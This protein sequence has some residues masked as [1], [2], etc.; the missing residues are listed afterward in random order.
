MPQSSSSVSLNR[1]QC[2]ISWIWRSVSG[3]RT[4]SSHSIA[5]STCSAGKSVLNRGRLT[6]PV[7]SR[8]TISGSR[9]SRP[10]ITGSPSRTGSSHS[11]WRRANQCSLDSRRCTSSR[12]AR[13]S[14]A[15]TNCAVSPGRQDAT[16]VLRADP[17]ELGQVA[18][19]GKVAVRSAD[20]RSRGGDA[21]RARAARA[22]ARRASS[23]RTAV[24]VGELLR[25]EPVRVERPQPVA[26][27]GRGTRRAGRRSP[28]RAV[29]GCGRD[30][31]GPRSLTSFSARR[32]ASIER[33]TPLDR[34]RRARA[35]SCPGHLGMARV[36]VLLDRAVLPAVAEEDVLR[37]AEELVV[38][39]DRRF[40][41]RAR[42]S[43]A[44]APACALPGSIRA[45]RAAACRPRPSCLVSGLSCSACP[46]RTPRRRGVGRC[47]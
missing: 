1:I 7:V 15:S 44:A 8:S 17:T 4:T 28:I 27:T 9:I 43:P 24:Q 30:V 18:A 47:P 23:C 3:C 6:V 21:A 19:V 41:D 32:E 25:V 42:R 40:L 33:P 5:V 35:A 29:R 14:P 46:C 36:E 20:R 38:A 26:P 31:A 13:S 11:T 10:L 16:M 37:V 39:R 45:V 2:S 22:R 34:G 12:P